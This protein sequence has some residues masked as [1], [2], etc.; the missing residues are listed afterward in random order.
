MDM[1]DDMNKQFNLIIYVD[2]SAMRKEALKQHTMANAYKGYMEALSIVY[3]RVMRNT[4][5][6]ALECRSR[7]PREILIMF[8]TEEKEFMVLI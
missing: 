3:C 6:N 5:I 8:G 7:S 4:I 1:Y 2:L